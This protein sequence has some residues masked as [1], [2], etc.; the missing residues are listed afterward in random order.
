MAGSAGL[1]PGDA[2]RKLGATFRDRG[3]FASSIGDAGAPRRQRPCERSGPGERADGTKETAVE[4][5]TSLLAK[6]RAVARRMTALRPPPG[7]CPPAAPALFDFDQ[8]ARDVAHG[9]P[10][11]DALRRRG[12]T[13]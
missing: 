10:R 13:L 6:I 5:R 9:L 11:R 12:T 2:E 4:N 7:E 3:E 1:P 8:P